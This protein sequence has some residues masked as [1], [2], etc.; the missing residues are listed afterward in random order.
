M[1]ISPSS[2]SS[3]DELVREALLAVELLGDRGDARLGEVAHGAP[4]QLLFVGQLVVHARRGGELRDQ[5]YA[6]AGA[7]RDPVVVAARALEETGARHVDVR[8]RPLAG[9]LLEELR[10]EHR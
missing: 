8:P 5:A 2:A 9:E 3:D 7:A 6:V 10:G 4:Q 1:P